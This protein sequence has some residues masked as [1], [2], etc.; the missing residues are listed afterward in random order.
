MT[1]DAVDETTEFTARVARRLEQEYVVW[2]TSVGR[3]GTPQPN[4]VWFLWDGTAF[5]V[6][7]SPRSHRVAHLRERP[8]VTLHLDGGPR[9]RDIVVL[10]G[11]AEFAADG[12]PPT[13][14]PAYM[15]K[16]GELILRVFG[17]H[18]EFD[19]THPLALRVVP[20]RVRGR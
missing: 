15:D 2:L 18:E 6:Y 1:Q 3:D 17:S 4:P 14:D 13:G 7:T 10:S 11:T 5:T 9:G 19:R 12:G 16:Y 20:D 8:R